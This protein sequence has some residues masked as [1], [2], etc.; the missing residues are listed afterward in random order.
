[1]QCIQVF[2]EI[3]KMSSYNVPVVLPMEGNALFSVRYN[4]MNLYS[5]QVERPVESSRKSFFYSPSFIFFLPLLYPIHA[6]NSLPSLFLQLS[7]IFNPQM[8]QFPIHTTCVTTRP[9]I[10]THNQKNWHLPNRGLLKWHQLVI[11]IP[12]VILLHFRPFSP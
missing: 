9:Y 3:F 7:D 6:F 5:I 2:R 12:L 8:A 11:I 10:T 4:K 1:M